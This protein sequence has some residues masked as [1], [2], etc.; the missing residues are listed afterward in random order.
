MEDALFRKKLRKNFSDIDTA[1]ASMSEN[2]LVI[3]FFEKVASHFK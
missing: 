2:I 1:R 3:F